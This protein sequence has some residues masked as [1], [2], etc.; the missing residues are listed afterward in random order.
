M[1]TAKVQ[2]AEDNTATFASEVT[3]ELYIPAEGEGTGETVL[4]ANLLNEN[5]Q[6]EVI[7]TVDVSSNLLEGIPHPFKVRVKK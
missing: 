7:L 5:A 6:Q 2:G 3:L 1:V 4:Y